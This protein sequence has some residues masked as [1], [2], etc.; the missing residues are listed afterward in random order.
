LDVFKLS[1]LDASCYEKFELLKE[2]FG[3]AGIEY[4]VTE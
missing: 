3:D 4:G 1:F 2:I